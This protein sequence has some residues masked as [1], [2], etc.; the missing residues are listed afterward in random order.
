MSE[1]IM[2][3]LLNEITRC[4]EVLKMYEEIPQGIFG[5]TMI[6]ASLARAEK[7]IIDNDVVEI[8]RAY[9]DLKEIE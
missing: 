1:N 4:R 2:Q 6:K 5:A 7:A 8:V 9:Q 3:G